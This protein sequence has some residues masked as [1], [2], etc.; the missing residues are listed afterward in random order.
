MQPSYNSKST[1]NLHAWRKG[2]TSKNKRKKLLKGILKEHPPSEAQVAKVKSILPSYVVSDSS[3]R[4]V[5]K[6]RSAVERKIRMREKDPNS[7]EYFQAIRY[8]PKLKAL[9]EAMAKQE[10]DAIQHNLRML[11]GDSISQENANRLRSKLL[12]PKSYPQIL[13]KSAS[14]RSIS[15]T[16]QSAHRQFA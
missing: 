6:R 15:P 1:P 4:D 8:A 9:E 7:G 16:H 10:A 14:Y 13:R 3:V 5:L 11:Y 2:L 12:S